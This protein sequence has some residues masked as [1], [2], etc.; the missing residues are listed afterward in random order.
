MKRFI[1]AYYWA[2]TFKRALYYCNNHKCYFYIGHRIPK[3]CCDLVCQFDT[4]KQ[5]LI[6]INEILLNELK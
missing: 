6:A 4:S 5:D 3:R 2:K 1:L